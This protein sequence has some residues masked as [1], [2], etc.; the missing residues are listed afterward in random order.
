MEVDGGL[1]RFGP[2]VVLLMF[3]A[4]TA[5]AYNTCQTGIV[6]TN[7]TH[8]RLCVVFANGSISFWNSTAC[9]KNTVCD[10]SRCLDIH[11]HPPGYAPSPRSCSI[12]GFVCANSQEYQL[13]RYDQYGSSYPWGPYYL[14]PHN[15]VCSEA[16]PYHCQTL[17]P[18]S[19]SPP[20]TG[21]LPLPSKDEY[22]SKNFVCVDSNTYLLC[23]DMGDGT[24]K[25]DNQQH[26]CPSTQICHK[27]FDKPCAGAKATGSSVCSK[28]WK[29]V[30]VLILLQAVYFNYVKLY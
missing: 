5:T 29:E 1:K 17:Y 23:R 15:T 16:H 8:F 22:K 20:A 4:T 12:H 27:S 14:C 6:C 24:F 25:P 9:P 11:P 13:C 19:Y 2:K 21:H 30:G 3:F 7:S 26:K 28:Q 18:S 10:V